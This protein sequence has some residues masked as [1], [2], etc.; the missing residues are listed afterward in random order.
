MISS[1]AQR[2][3]V[4]SPPELW[5]ELS[6]VE[7][8]N[9]HLGGLGEIRITRVEP[10]TEVEWETDGANGAVHLKQSGWG[11]RVTL[12]LTREIPTP[13]TPPES[14]ADTPLEPTPAASEPPQTEREPPQPDPVT[15]PHEPDLGSE[16]EAS[17]ETER[18]PEGNAEREPEANA[19]RE[20]EANAER[21]PEAN[22][23]AEPEPK[24][25]SR[26]EPRARFFARLFRRGR[27]RRTYTGP[28]REPQS[29]PEP[30]LAAPP[31]PSAPSAPSAPAAPAAPAAPIENLAAPEPIY[32]E[33][34]PIQAT[35]RPGADPT[36]EPATDPMV[37]PNA[38][39]TA[40]ATAG[41][42]AE[43]AA[44]EA[45]MAREDSELL[46]GVLDRLGAAHHRPFSRG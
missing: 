20:P 45:Q 6:S 10:E 22:A 33:P 13:R 37:E 19:E 28:E 18:E 43:L 29:A 25:T 4:K 42:A 27:S 11:T 15:A 8:L 23:E 30:P 36:A 17:A 32:P 39:P 7:G 46:T 2:T 35:P 31:A 12:S 34:I 26:P 21:E 44:I 41:P 16:P 14:A 5:A 9:R 24:P 40:D 3:L 38:D 1:E